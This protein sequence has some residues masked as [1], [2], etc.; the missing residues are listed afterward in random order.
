MII[1]QTPTALPESMITNCSI[2]IVHRLGNDLDAQLMTTMLCRNA[3][4]D[5]NDAIWLVKQSIGTAIIRIS[6]TVNHQN[7]NHVLYKLQD[8]KTNHLIMKN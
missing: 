4:L 1:V 3:R 2:L 8:A 5:G 6:N 7:Q